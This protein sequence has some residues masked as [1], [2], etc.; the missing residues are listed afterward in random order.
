MKSKTDLRIY[1]KEIRKSLDIKAISE[2]LVDLIR[3]SDIY[4]LA[5]N[6]MIFYPKKDEIDLRNLLNDDKN[7]F[8]PKVYEDSLLVCPYTQELELANYNIMEPCSDPVN[9]SVLDLVIV[10]AL[11]VDSQGYRLGYGG[12]FYDRFLKT[13]H[14]KTLV[15]MPKELLVDKLPHDEFD[16]K[17]D[18]IILK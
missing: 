11:M 18:E 7:F 10:P 9:P 4:K 8:L 15:A 1:A 17:I 2:N 12:G 3:Q 6:V 16:V 13:C 14:V 5:K